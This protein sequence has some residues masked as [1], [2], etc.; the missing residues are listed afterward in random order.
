MRRIICINKDNGNHFNQHEA[1]LYYGWIE[2]GTSEAYR[3]DRQTMVNWV[4]KGNIA[5]VAV[6]DY[7]VNCFVNKN[8]HSGLEFLQ[9]YSDKIPNDNL[10]H[11]DECKLSQ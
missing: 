8:P 9:T 4:K 2:D 5:Y 10:L 6:N 7:R 1:V 11:L 3:T